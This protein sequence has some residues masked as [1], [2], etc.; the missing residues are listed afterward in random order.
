MMH[1]TL[2]YYS[3]L[4]ELDTYA[5]AMM[6]HKPRAYSEAIEQSFKHRVF[7]YSSN[8]STSVLYATLLITT[9]V[10]V[11][12]WECDISASIS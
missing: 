12:V 7:A 6:H 11:E 10:I 2:F 5:T 1:V 8:I 3:L 4:H 9:E